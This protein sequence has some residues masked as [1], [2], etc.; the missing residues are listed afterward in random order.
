MMKIY[1]KT[2]RDKKMKE[3]STIK[4]G[5]WIKLVNP[6]MEEIRKIKE[7]L[8]LPTDFIL[9]PLDHDERPRVEKKG[10]KILIIIRVPH[11]IFRA[12]EREVLTIP[13]G[14]IVLKDCI[15]SICRYD[16]EITKSLEEGRVKPFYTTQKTRFLLYVFKQTNYL[17]NKYLEE[18]EREIR[19][20]EN[21]VVTSLKNEEII[22]LLN[23][24]KT[25]VY[26]NA[27]IIANDKVFERIARG[28]LIK[29]YE[30]DQDLIEDIVLDNREIMESVEVF[31]NILSNTM[32]AYASIVSNNLNIVM[33]M[34]T[35]FTII[36]SIP[37]IIFSAYGMNVKLPM[38]Y[39]PFTFWM[40]WAI[41]FLISLW[42]LWVFK[43]IRWM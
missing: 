26:F 36:L 30:K 40:L 9:S 25:L 34:L 19:R 39:H 6:S 16:D 31:S 23:F 22:R 20:I 43:K 28:K 1:L 17:Y 37:T 12:G 32:D 24:Q 33:K 41:S 5:C 38:Q 8:K 3:I 18:I 35:V 29:L 14:L 27:S 42:L 2:V 4:K 7:E 15:V 21:F 13:L 11:K 10:G